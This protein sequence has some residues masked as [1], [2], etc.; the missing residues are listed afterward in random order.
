MTFNTEVDI[1]LLEGDKIEDMEIKI[2]TQEDIV[3]MMTIN[4]AE[5]T[6][7]I[8][9]EATI[10][11]MIDMTEV[12]IDMTEAMDQAI[13]FSEELTM[14]SDRLT[15]ILVPRITTTILQSMSNLMRNLP[16]KKMT[17]HSKTLKTKITATFQRRRNPKVTNQIM[18]P[19]KSPKTKRM[20]KSKS[21]TRKSTKNTTKSTRNPKNRAR[22]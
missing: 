19:Q 3:I 20:K 12:T 4:L 6:I 1:Q 2:D 17:S 16:Q 13:T 11:V 18:M 9:I 22:K 5:E 14:S 15:N 10:E 8:M 21:S 7:G